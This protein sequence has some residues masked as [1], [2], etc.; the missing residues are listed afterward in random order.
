[1]DQIES[2]L[3][4]A[5]TVVDQ[6][7]HHRYWLEPGVSCTIQRITSIGCVIGQRSAGGGKRIPSRFLDRRE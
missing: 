4:Y 3:G 7:F 1:M 6:R 5:R 2:S